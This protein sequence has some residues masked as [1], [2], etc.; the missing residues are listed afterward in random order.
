MLSTGVM[1]AFGF[2]FWIICSRLF[3]PQDVGLATAFISAVSLVSG[4]SMLGFN[5][6]IIRFLPTSDR[7]DD[8][9][10]TAIII[11]IIA[12]LLAGSIFLL[13]AITTHSPIIKDTATFWW[14]LLFILYLWVGSLNTV[15]ESVFIAYRATIYIVFKNTLFSILKLLLPLLL[16]SI[17][18][19]AIIGSITIALA[20]SLG[21]GL[22]WLTTKFNYRP[23]LHINA[24]VIREIYT[25]A[26]GNYVGNLFSMLPGTL[27]P[28]IVLSRLGAKEAA[29]FYM[30]M[31][32]ISFLNIIPSA[33]AQSLFAEVSHD[34]KELATHLKSSLKHLSLIILPAGGAIVFF[35]AFVL[36]FF[37]PI[38]AQEG[39]L[40][41]QILVIASLF[42][43]L[44]Y[45]GDTLLN[46]KKR[47]NLYIFMNAFNALII[48]ILVYYMAP[49][50]LAAVATASL[51]G[52]IITLVVYFVINWRLVG[53]F[54]TTTRT[55]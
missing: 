33:S 29:F 17:G 16:F 5:N 7:K 24:T 13:W 21:I 6:S 32:I 1:A 27:V 2:V 3:T 10:S 53:E 51:I 28:L 46:I 52:Q 49:R 23:L 43:A 50:G 47:M 35:G 48:V 41:L 40:P 36:S 31:M 44:N 11:T 14:V 45:F 54:W 37:G 22:V 25:F 34:E 26:A 8:Q 19:F 18:A 15:I 30:P 12:N 39:A 55:T 42:G 20:I 38:Y 9:I 4:L